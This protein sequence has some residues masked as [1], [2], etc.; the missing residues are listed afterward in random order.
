MKYAI[1][2]MTALFLSNLAQLPAIAQ[3]PRALEISIF[4]IGPAVDAEAVSAVRRVIGNAVSRGVVDTYITYGY[5]IEG[6]SASCIQ[7]SRFEDSSSLV[8]LER[9][10]SRIQPNRETT[11]YEVRAVAA[12]R[13]A[14]TSPTQVSEQLTN[15]EWVL[16]DLGGTAAIANPQKPMLRF[17]SSD[18]IAGQGGCNSYSAN[19]Q[20]DG[21]RLAVSALVSTRRACVDLQ[22]QEQENR[23]FR[24]L[25]NAQWVSLEGS[26][27]LIYSEA[28]N[29]PLRFSR[30]TSN[31]EGS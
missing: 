6:G 26:E 14:S 18:R 13:Q 3:T 2:S 12:C 29:V 11:S 16:E 22:V 15:S 19:F 9:E 25:E 8:Q 7:L 20:L 28:F 21:V 27:L 24:A 4:G 5:G 1:L 30:V 23:Y 10:L 17:T 31:S